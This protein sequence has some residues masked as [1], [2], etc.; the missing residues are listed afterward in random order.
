VSTGFAALPKDKQREVRLARLALEHCPP[1]RP[2][3]WPWVVA[4]LTFLLGFA[5]G[6]TL[7]AGTT[8]VSLLVRP[9]LMLQRGDIRIEARVPRSAENRLLSIAWSSDTGSEG[10]TLRQLEGEDAAVLHTLWLPGQPP[11]NYLFVATVFN[12]LGKP[13]GRAE[14]RIVVPDGDG[15]HE[16]P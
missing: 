11:A 10:S 4:V 15:R 6:V 16:R 13:R 7:H 1:P 8:P 12:T 9:Q 14:A 2:P 5:A 3:R